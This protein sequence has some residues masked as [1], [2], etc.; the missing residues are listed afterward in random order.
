MS[1]KVEDQHDLFIIMSSAGTWLVEQ[2]FPL[3]LNYLTGLYVTCFVG[4][5][6]VY[7]ISLN[8]NYRNYSK[9]HFELFLLFQTFDHHCPWVNNCIGRRNYRYFFLFLLSLSVHKVSIFSLCLIHVL[10][11]QDTL[12]DKG[13]IVAYPFIRKVFWYSI[14]VLTVSWMELNNHWNNIHIRRS[15]LKLACPSVSFS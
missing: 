14:H 7:V 8:V 11:N 3:S 1:I 10:D 4:S 6:C 9:Y 13:N 2:T 12:K 15:I 5:Y